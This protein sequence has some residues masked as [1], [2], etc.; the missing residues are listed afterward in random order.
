[1]DRAEEPGNLG[2]DFGPFT[3]P[4]RPKP[5]LETGPGSRARGLDALLSN[6]EQIC[7]RSYHTAALLPGGSGGPPSKGR[8]PPAC[9]VY[10]RIIRFNRVR[11]RATWS[12]CDI[13][14]LPTFPASPCL[15]RR[16]GQTRLHSRNVASW[17][18]PGCGSKGAP[19][20]GIP[21]CFVGQVF[22]GEA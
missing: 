17:C 7:C 12:R 11:E 21:K 10:R 5:V 16:S 13:Y 14:T 9:S 3:L 1:M 4:L 20:K 2:L 15:N 18:G 19:I 8:C 22:F 6:L